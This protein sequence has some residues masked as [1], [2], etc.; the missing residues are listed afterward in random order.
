MERRNK[1]RYEHLKLMIRSGDIPSEPDTPSETS[2]EEAD[3]HEA[4]THPQSKAV[5]AGT[6]QATSHQEALP[7]IQAVDP[8]IPIQS[9]PPLQQADPQTATTETPATRPSS[10][11][12]PSHPT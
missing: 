4:E 7:Q 3:D 5:Q 6:E 2:E 8:E 9:A 12:T 11:D 10:D 1:R